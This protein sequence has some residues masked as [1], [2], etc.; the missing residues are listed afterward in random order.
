MCDCNPPNIDSF[1]YDQSAFND[2]QIKVF[3]ETMDR[4]CALVRENI[5]VLAKTHI[6]SKY[7][8][9]QLR[10]RSLYHDMSKRSPNEYTPYILR[11]WRTHCKKHSIDFH[12][13]IPGKYIGVSD[14][15]IRDGVFHH[16]THNQHHPEW[17][18]DPDDMGHVDLAEMVADWYAMS[19]EHKSS[20]DDWIAYV[21]PRRYHFQNAL[22][23]I[24]SFVDALKEAYPVLEN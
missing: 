21:I 24:H 3:N 2:A 12:E 7:E 14:Q 18:P 1:I 20:I 22:P 16:I 19:R 23:M 10:S 13:T 9:D 8:L 11:Y 15:I 6:W 17:W 4:H 5:Q